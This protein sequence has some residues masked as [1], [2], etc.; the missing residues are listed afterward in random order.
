[1]TTISPNIN[2]FSKPLVKS[3]T[4][5][6]GE[7]NIYNERI[8]L[9]G[10]NNVIVNT[11]ITGEL[12]PSDK[13]IY[14]VFKLYINGRQATQSGF[15]GEIIPKAYSLENTAMV[16]SVNFG[17]TNAPK[18]SVRLT[19]QVIGPDCHTCIIDNSIGAH[20]GAKGAFLQIMT[21]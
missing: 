13:D 4:N 8:Q 5:T 17:L 2:M 20:R 11:S 19:G 7:V 9:T 14:V 10:T 3:F 18:V 6:D 15:E 1:M 12:V 16:Y 21:L